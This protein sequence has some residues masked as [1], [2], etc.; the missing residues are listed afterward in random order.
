MT[1][2]KR[3][4]GLPASSNIPI[5]D[6]HVHTKY[7][8]CCKENYGIFE[9][10]E[11][12]DTA[13]LAG[14]G[15][16]DY[17][18]NQHFNVKFLETQRKE[19]VTFGL[20]ASMRLGLEITILDREGHLSVNP[21]ALDQLDFVIVAEHLDVAK[22]FDEFHNLKKKVEHWRDAGEVA[23]IRDIAIKTQELMCGG[24]LTSPPHTILAHPWRFFLSRQIY[25]PTILEL[26]P[27]LCEVAQERGIAIEMPGSHLKVWSD[28]EQQ[29]SL[30]EFLRSFWRLVGHYDVQIAL[31]SDAHRIV[32]VGVF[33]E[34][35]S[36]FNDLGLSPR[37]LLSFE[38][39]PFKETP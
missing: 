31:G 2:E 13:G 22:N 6:W 36:A 16:S 17:S 15:I 10:G 28:R 7:S 23:K 3:V 11:A 34:M 24:M 1:L 14:A 38:D 29:H 37:R 32:D 33:P 4:G 39:I 19:M 30:Y 26:T 20:Q 35:S 21:K 5:V 25:E 12:A 8:S 27:R 18:N 9:V